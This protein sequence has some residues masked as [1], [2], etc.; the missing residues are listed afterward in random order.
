MPLSIDVLSNENEK[1]SAKEHIDKFL[2]VSFKFV[3]PNRKTIWKMSERF[4]MLIIIVWPPTFSISWSG[5]LHIVL[6]ALLYTILLI[7]RN[8]LIVLTRKWTN[9]LWLTDSQH[10]SEYGIQLWDGFHLTCLVGHS[11]LRLMNLCQKV[12]NLSVVY[13]RVRCWVLFCFPFLWLLWVKSFALF[14]MLNIN[15]ALCRWYTD[16]HI[17][18]AF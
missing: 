8:N 4:T 1:H 15:F 11:L 13:H 12:L 9:C 5:S 14:Q 6:Y 10:G 18:D 7:N 3:V 2:A 16:I 17:H